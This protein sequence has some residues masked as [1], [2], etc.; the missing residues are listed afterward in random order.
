[1]SEVN[2]LSVD[3]IPNVQ[4]EVCPEH[5]PCATRLQKYGIPVYQG[6][7]AGQSAKADLGL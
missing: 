3:Q 5:N 1:M 6:R 4:P 2:S 7:F